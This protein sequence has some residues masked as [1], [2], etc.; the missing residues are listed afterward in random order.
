MKILKI[1]VP[2]LVVLIALFVWLTP[3]GPV[4]GFF[5]GGSQSEAPDTWGDTSSI[6]EIRLK[7][8]SGSLPRVVII[9]VVQVDNQLYIVGSRESG[10]VSMLAQGGPVLM[11]LGDKTY[12]LI[13]NPVTMNW[14]SIFNTYKDK[15]RPDYPDIVNGMSES[16]ESAETPAVY[17]LTRT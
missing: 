16:E 2:I 6:H 5:I 3:I 7:V 14:Q 8:N 4:S 17:R 13:A 15:Y 9:W 1:V 12:S 11:R 10:W